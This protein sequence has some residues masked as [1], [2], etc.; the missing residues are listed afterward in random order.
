M[1]KTRL[2]KRSNIQIVPMID[3]IFFLLIFFM[4][5][6]TFRITPE[7][8]DLRLPQAT[9][10][11]GQEDDSIVIAITKTGETFLDGEPVSK[12]SLQERT[13]RLIQDNANLVVIIKA[14]EEVEYRHVVEV[15]DQVRIVGA[16]RI[17]LAAD[18][19]LQ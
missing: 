18:R 1:F 3:V 4:L 19:K 16:Y 10:V 6:T 8:L 13:Q 5:F 7:G 9:T 15:M 17:A 2:K 11:T 12:A 14:H